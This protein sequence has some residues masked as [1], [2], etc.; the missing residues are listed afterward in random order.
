[1]SKN[2]KESL[3]EKSPRDVGDEA[4]SIAVVKGPGGTWRA[5]Y[6][7]LRGEQVVRREVV[8]GSEGTR[9]IALEAAK[10]AFVE[11]LWRGWR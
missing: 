11:R 4:K 2:V 5:E 9:A 10:I 8:K 1:M 6:L 7:E 3:K